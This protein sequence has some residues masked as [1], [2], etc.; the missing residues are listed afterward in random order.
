MFIYT[1]YT[2][3]GEDFK[4]TKNVSDLFVIECDYILCLKLNY[5]F[6][7]QIDNLQLLQMK[8]K[9]FVLRRSGCWWSVVEQHFLTPWIK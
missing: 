4:F 8:K 9:E 5:R 7:Y 2:C 1:V 3:V 6:L